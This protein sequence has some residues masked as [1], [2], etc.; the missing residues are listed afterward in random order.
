[1]NQTFYNHTR[2]GYLEYGHTIKDNP[3]GL[4]VKVKVCGCELI[5]KAKMTR[6]EKA[7]R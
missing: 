1:M 3:W 7:Y 5:L 2:F 4:C 6:V